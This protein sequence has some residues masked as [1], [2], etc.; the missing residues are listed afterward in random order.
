[1]STRRTAAQLATDRA[2]LLDALRVAGAETMWVRPPADARPADLDALV[3]AGL[4]KREVRREW[5]R[6]VFARGSESG[7]FGGA[8][9]VQRHRAYYRLAAPEAPAEVAETVTPQPAATTQRLDS[10]RW[11]WNLRTSLG[12]FT[13]QMDY[14][15]EAEAAAAGART[16]EARAAAEA[17]KNLA[18]TVTAAHPGA[19]RMGTPP[20]QGAPMNTT[21]APTTPSLTDAEWVT[22]KHISAGDW[23]AAKAYRASSPAPELKLVAAKTI[24]SNGMVTFTLA[25]G[26]TH[27]GGVASKWFRVAGA[28]ATPETPEAA[29]PAEPTTLTKTQAKRVLGTQVHLAVGALLHGWDDGGLLAQSMTRAEAQ[30]QLEAWLRYIPSTQLG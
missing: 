19:D 26:T 27:T 16:A 2:A 12:R 21:P 6:Q 9:S 20:S 17:G 14:L 7:L 13:S 5:D 1:M 23:M 30:E 3:A 24:A 25:D 15:T 8:G 18:E 4:V 22:T 11:V 10:G 28:E 29:T